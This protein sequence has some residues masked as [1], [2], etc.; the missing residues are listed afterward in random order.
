MKKKASD[1]VTER[2]RSALDLDAPGVGSNNGFHAF[3]LGEFLQLKARPRPFL[4]EPILRERDIAMVYAWRGVGKTWFAH[5]VALAVATGSKFLKW[6]APLQNYVLLVDGEMP[7]AALQDRWRSAIAGFSDAADPDDI[8]VK[9][10]P[11]DA[12]DNPLPSLT[13]VAGQAIIEENIGD[14]R[15]LI[16][17]NI[18]TL[19]ENGNEN[20][21]DSWNAAQAWLLRL[22]RN[23]VAVMLVHHTGKGGAQRGTSKR[24][25]ILD[26]SI[27]LQRPAE[28]RASE[29]ARFEVVFEKARHLSGPEADSFEA[30]LD[31]DCDNRQVWT[32]SDPNESKRQRALE[33]LEIPGMSIRDVA[34]ELRVAKSTIAYWKKQGKTIAESIEEKRQELIQA[35]LDARA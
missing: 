4:L 14:A 16:L 22:R 32:I 28:Y 2:M 34:N 26:L 12:F 30:R 19:L 10:L 1:E 20:D 3:P 11:V 33:M 6:S 29:G 23:G 7:T 24:E 18:S 21:S 27:S 17:D 35:S 5:G 13:T 25:D 8:P 9:L 15:L 31:V